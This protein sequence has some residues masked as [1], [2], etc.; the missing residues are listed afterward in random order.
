MV[1]VQI[2]S[3]ATGSE[4]PVTRAVGLMP[5]EEVVTVLLFWD[6]GDSAAVDG[7]L[8]VSEDR[9]LSDLI[10]PTLTVVV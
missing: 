5:V 4:S 6:G 9:S 8:S 7:I 3:W 10:R 2:L 1:C